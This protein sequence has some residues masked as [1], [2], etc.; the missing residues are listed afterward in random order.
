MRILKYT[1]V[2]F[3]KVK[4]KMW[5]FLLLVPACALF[6]GAE[7]GAMSTMAVAYCL[8]AGI[9]FAG[10]PYYYE[11]PEEM[12]FFYLLPG[13]TEEQV[14]GH[15]LFGSL[16]LLAGLGLGI[17]SSSISS[18][19]HTEHETG[20]NLLKSISANEPGMSEIM[21]LLFGAGLICVAVQDFFCTLFRFESVQVM[22]IMRILP[23]FI[24]FFG[25]SML[26]SYGEKTPAEILQFL[27][28]HS[29]EVFLSC[30][31]VY[32]FTAFLSSM[33]AKARE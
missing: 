5:I 9:I 14:F 12:G 27:F 2:D 13:R 17:F 32:L 33:I 4:K 10:M 20:D 8:F 25:L 22:N 1:L 15:F 31:A 3:L 21:L 19:F 7:S 23:G 18:L 6:M 11:K 28:S 30:L 16:S 29:I 24:F 26:L